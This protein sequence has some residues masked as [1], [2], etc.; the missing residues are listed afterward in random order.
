MMGLPPPAQAAADLVDLP[1]GVF[2]GGII[3]ES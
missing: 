2:V 3:D 1:G